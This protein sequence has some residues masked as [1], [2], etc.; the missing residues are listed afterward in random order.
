MRD[1]SLCPRVA[2]GLIA[3]LLILALLTV[4]VPIPSTEALQVTGPTFFVDFNNSS[5]LDGWIIELVKS[6]DNAGDAAYAVTDGV[7]KV[8]P[9]AKGNVSEWWGLHFRRNVSGWPS[10]WALIAVYH[11]KTYA[12]SNTYRVFVGVYDE[13]GTVIAKGGL[14]DTST[15]SVATYAIAVIGGSAYASSSSVA[16]KSVI[17]VTVILY[18]NGELAVYSKAAYQVDVQCVEASQLVSESPVGIEIAVEF[19]GEYVSTDGNQYVEVKWI[20]VLSQSAITV[21]NADNVKVIDCEGGEVVYDA[22]PPVDVLDLYNAFSGFTPFNTFTFIVE[23]QGRAEVYTREGLPTA[24]TCEI[25]ASVLYRITTDMPA[26]KPGETLQWTIEASEPV[27]VTLSLQLEYE[28]GTDVYTSD[29]VL[30]GKSKTGTIAVAEWPDSIYRLAIYDSPGTMLA[31]TYVVIGNQTRYVYIDRYI[32]YGILYE[33][34]APNEVRPDEKITI[35]FKRSITEEGQTL[36]EAS[37]LLYLKQG[38]ATLATKPITLQAG[39]ET[40][41]WTVDLSIFKLEKGWLEAGAVIDNVTIKKSILVKASVIERVKGWLP[42]SFSLNFSSF[43]SVFNFSKLKEWFEGFKW[44]WQKSETRVKVSIT[45][46]GVTPDQVI[47]KVPRSL[48]FDERI[49][50]SYN[51]TSGCWEAEVPANTT[52]NVVVLWG[53]YYYRTS[54]KVGNGG[55]FTITWPSNPSTK[56]WWDRIKEKLGMWP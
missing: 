46:S 9:T 25:G 44:P 7:L 15:A 12:S 23:K 34:Q 43:S 17:G 47:V 21:D 40:F 8:Q 36:P 29:V 53:D 13:N 45:V 37:V 35:T 52:I 5:D 56:S 39:Q 41:N 28:N 19:N 18:S 20:E 2:G 27:S 38:E 26:Y 16:E 48:W 4:I 3:A 24:L 31:Y 50:A 54:I 33:I 51:T 42:F 14:R 30:D 55:S 32:H 22:A 49:T 11:A 10:E 6:G 1:G